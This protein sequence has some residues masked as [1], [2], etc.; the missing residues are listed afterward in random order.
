M[1]NQDTFEPVGAADFIARLGNQAQEIRQH[2]DHGGLIFKLGEPATDAQIVA[3]ETQLGITLPPPVKAFYKVANGLRLRWGSDVELE[4]GGEDDDD[5]YANAAINIKPVEN[6]LEDYEGQYWFADQHDDGPCPFE[7]MPFETEQ[8][9][10]KQLRPFDEGRGDTPMFYLLGDD[11][12]RL[13]IGEDHGAE[14]EASEPLEQ[15]LGKLLYCYGCLM[16]L[17]DEPDPGFTLGDII[18]AMEDF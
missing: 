13:F 16:F 18:E 6:A 1:T 3:V 9:F 14:I 10:R 17:E 4:E 12:A 8:A 5:M 11:Q 7:G 2:A 15:Y